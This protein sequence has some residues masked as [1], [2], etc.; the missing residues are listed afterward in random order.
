MAVKLTEM[1]SLTLLLSNAWNS[2][3]SP[4]SGTADNPTAD[5]QT[6]I[7]PGPFHVSTEI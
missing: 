2:G 6:R 1:S 7:V 5:L 4:L 3:A